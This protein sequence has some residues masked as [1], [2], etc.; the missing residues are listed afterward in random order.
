LNPSSSVFGKTYWSASGFSKPVV[1]LLI[2]LWLT[3]NL[4]LLGYLGI[5]TGSDTEVYEAMA[6]ALLDGDLPEGRL[7]WYISY[8]A[9]LAAI[10]KLGGNFAWVVGIQILLSGVAAI[11]LAQAIKK[12]S[13]D[14]RISLVA[15]FMYLAWVKIHQWNIFIYT[16][17]LFTS[18]AVISFA[19]FVLSRRPWQHVLSA[20]LVALTFFARP[21][22]FSFLAG[23]LVYGLVAVP[24]AQ[25]WKWATVMIAVGGALLLLNLMLKDF[26]LVESYAKGEII[27]PAINLG[28]QPP[29]HIQVPGDEY[30][31]L[32]RLGLFVWHQPGY[33]IKIS[34]IKLLLFFA[35]AK[36]YFSLLHNAL[37]VLLLYPLYFFA[38]IGYRHFPSSQL[39]YFILGFIGSQAAT[40]MLTTNDWDGRF[41]VLAL[42]FIFMMS[43]VGIVYIFTKKASSVSERG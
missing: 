7:L 42:P 1:L 18:L 24:M 43:A 31:P 30:G 2:L 36:P 29:A 11:F 5:R 9:L 37:I 32:V 15:V 39:K 12:M 8:I 21:T 34:L 10:F 27:Y 35:N 6:Y 4:L 13:G 28:L 38:V 3:I 33:F 22:G 41:L 25:K 14:T 20:L 19:A 17:S 40:V 26:V 23:W 16:E